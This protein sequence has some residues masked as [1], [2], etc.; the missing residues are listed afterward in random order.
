MIETLGNRKQRPEDAVGA[1][2]HA[3]Q[4]PTGDFL[5]D[6]VQNRLAQAVDRVGKEIDRT[7]Q[8]W[9]HLQPI[10]ARRLQCTDVAVKAI[11]VFAAIEMM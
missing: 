8:G 6:L 10:E 4:R 7:F 5:R 9:K 3:P 2:H 1:E 11:G